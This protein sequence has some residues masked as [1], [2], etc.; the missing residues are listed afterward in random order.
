MSRPLPRVRVRFPP[1]MSSAPSALQTAERLLLVVLL[2]SSPPPLGWLSVSHPPTTPDPNLGGG[3]IR[4]V[5]ESSISRNL[6][7]R[8][9]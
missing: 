4:H 5:C 6:W 3:D 1:F 9:E 8:K 2:T 7:D